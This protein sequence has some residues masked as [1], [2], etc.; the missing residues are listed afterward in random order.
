MTAPLSPDLRQRAL[1][2]LFRRAVPSARRQGATPS[3]SHRHQADAPRTRDRHGH[4]DDPPLRPLRQRAASARESPLGPWKT[5][6]FVAGLRHNG[7]IAPLVPDGPM[8]GP[9]F[10]AYVEQ[11]SAPAL[12]PGDLVVS[13]NLSAHKVAGVG[14]AIAARG[15][16]LMYLPPISTRSSN[17]SQS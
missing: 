1:W 4:Q 5:T 3:A 2:P 7:I 16:S 9:A 17:C 14:E 15:A 12:A 8:D 6:T 13:D 10:R 11:A